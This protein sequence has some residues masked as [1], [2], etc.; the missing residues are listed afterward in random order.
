MFRRILTPGAEHLRLLSTQ[1]AA[2]QAN[3]AFQTER[4]WH[5][6]MLCKPP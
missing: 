5:L 4:C 6:L 1:S 2:V 3:A